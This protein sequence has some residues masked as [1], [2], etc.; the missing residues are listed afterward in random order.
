MTKRL[1]EIGE[2]PDGISIAKSIRVEKHCL[3]PTD[4]IWARHI[5]DEDQ[6][7]L[8]FGTEEIEISEKKFNRVITTRVGNLISRTTYPIDI[9]DVT[10]PSRVRIHRSS[11]HRYEDDLWILEIEFEYPEEQS[12]FEPYDWVGEDVTE[13]FDETIFLI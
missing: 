13:S 9:A 4:D 7:D 12:L 1:F 2:V 6:Y 3:S 5:V 10:D 11:L 8:I